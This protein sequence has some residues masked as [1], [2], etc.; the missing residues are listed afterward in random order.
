MYNK[1]Y[2]CLGHS[3]RVMLKMVYI[4]TTLF[5]CSMKWISRNSQCQANQ[6]TFEG[7]EKLCNTVYGTPGT[8]HSVCLPFL[9]PFLYSASLEGE[10]ASDP[11]PR[12]IQSLCGRVCLGVDK[13]PICF[14]NYLKGLGRGYDKQL[15]K[16]CLFIK[17]ISSWWSL[18]N[19]WPSNSRHRGSLHSF[20]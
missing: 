9:L 14:H 17:S 6:L 4:W 20:I 10:E 15:A 12:Y 11:G 1:T 16:Q 19:C 2:R 7:G 5:V 3:K 13:K 18:V 8:A